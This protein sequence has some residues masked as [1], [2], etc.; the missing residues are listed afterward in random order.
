[1]GRIQAAGAQDLFTFPLDWGQLVGPE[2][3]RPDVSP[4]HMVN[5]MDILGF[6]LE[7]GEKPTHKPLDFLY[8]DMG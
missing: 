7:L 2:N 4:V 6:H 8:V 3:V 1:M 5:T